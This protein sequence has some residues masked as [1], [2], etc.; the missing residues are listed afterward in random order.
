[1]ESAEM[2]DRLV[3]LFA[4][5]GRFHGRYRLSS[6]PEHGP[7]TIIPASAWEL[8]VFP[9]GS[10]GCDLLRVYAFDTTAGQLF[11][12]HWRNETRALLRLSTRGHPA[13]PRLREA[14][15][16]AQ[17]DIGYLIL[18]DP[19]V[20]LA[21]HTHLLSEFGADRRRAFLVF[22]SIVEAVGAMHEEG[23]LHRNLSL[24]SL[25]VPDQEGSVVIDGFQ[26]SSFMA[27]WFRP[28]AVARA[29]AFTPTDVGCRWMLA[30][31][32]LAA[33]E[34]LPTRD[35][36]TYAADV[37][38]LGMIGIRLL[39]GELTAPPD[40]FSMDRH[41][42]WLDLQKT[43]L[44]RAKLPIALERALDAMTAPNRRNRIP[45]AVA[46]YDHL[47]TSYNAILGDLEW[48]AGEEPPPFELLYLQESIK[49]LWEDGRGQSHYSDPHYPEYN[50]LIEQD[51]ARA[52]LSWS[53][54][55]FAPWE[56]GGDRARAA[57]ARVV[58][59]GRAY[60]YF[61]EP[62]D[63]GFPTEDRDR[64]V[65]KQMLPVDRAGALRKAPR[66]RAAPR[67]VCSYL[68]PVPFRGRR[69]PRPVGTGAWGG[70][71][72]TVQYEGGRAAQDPVIA[73]GHWLIDAQRADLR[74]RWFPVRVLHH[75][76]D[77]LHLRETE[78]Q[79]SPVTDAQ[80]AFDALW[81]CVASPEPMATVLG[82]LARRAEE[83]DEMQRFQLKRRRGDRDSVAQVRLEKRLDPYT[84]AFRIVTD[85]LAVPDEGE[86]CWITPN[87]TGTL[88]NLSRQTD[89]LHEVEQRYS[90]LAAQLRF[91]RAVR[92]PTEQGAGS[93][94]DPPTE[95]DALVRRIHE[96]WPI[97]A[98]QGP[99]G[100]GKT[101]AAAELIKQ[102]LAD[103][104]FARILVSAQSHHALDNLLNGVVERVE[105]HAALRVASVGTADR[106][107]QQ[108]REYQLTHRVDELMKRIA[109]G[110]ANDPRST[111]TIL[112]WRKRAKNGDIELRAD[113]SRR[114]PRASSPVFTTSAQATSDGLGS[115]RGAGS[116]DWVIIEEAARGWLTEFFIPMVQGARWCLVGDQAQLKAHRQDEFERLLKRDIDDQITASAVGIGATGDWMPFLRHFEHL[117]TVGSDLHAPRAHLTLQRRMHPDIAGLVA[118]AFYPKLGLQTAPEVQHDREHGL[119][120]DPY[121]GTAL[122]WLDTA[123]LGP[124]AHES[125]DGGLMNFC[126][127]RVIDYFFRNRVGIPRVFDPRV[128]P[129]AVLSPYKRQRRLL[130]E[131]LGYGD[132]VVRTVDSFQGRQAEVVVVSLVRSNAAEQTAEAIGFLDDS[133]RANVMFSRARRLLV[134][135]GNLGHFERHQAGSFWADVVSYFRGDPRFVVDVSKAGFRHE[136]RGP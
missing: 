76:G 72:P 101:H 49:H 123:S 1:M 64:L 30:P 14:D 135:V 3:P 105:S 51:L 74:R 89:A 73:A 80:G 70:L 116:F 34:G 124:N 39:V 21:R 11:Q 91:P 119:Q 46:A 79:E 107:E 97:F 134:V 38:S 99:P 10:L 87:D 121:A 68:S 15:Y 88:T 43:A 65:V 52:V 36:E 131:K 132:E 8:P 44:R 26:M 77:L 59:L 37:F 27:A 102:I 108:A 31:E 4:E 86:D 95:T 45:S 35:V 84:C 92:L 111:S 13:L 61:C 29:S 28:T 93:A 78:A 81:A 18:S 85:T 25:R 41:A 130:G 125:S 66:Q 127:W 110:T 42:A 62:L 32:R 122:V 126:E 20:E 115:S 94:S 129:L 40:S 6:E 24:D 23:L 47:S 55:G 16:L 57:T 69:P 48:R 53:P 96:T 63:L 117:M 5:G 60:A 50:E 128:P 106:V 75:H 90:H 113:I 100:T 104:P 109:Q 12:A 7:E 114:L 120:M 136:R 82:D 19:G 2:L 17:A 54:D 103:D 67:V 33:L 58:L 133:S 9:V 98:L 71:T 22:F 112:E 83:A 118:H 56:R